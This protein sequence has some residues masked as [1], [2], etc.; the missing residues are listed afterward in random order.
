MVDLY[1]G[2][3]NTHW[4]LHEKLLC[5]WSPFFA[6]IFYDKKTDRAGTTKSYGLPDED[7]HVFEM[8][9]GWLYSRTVP[10]PR[11][12]KEIGPLLELY[13]LAQ[14]L[15][16]EKLSDE[17][18]ETVREFYHSN[19]TYPGLRRVQYIYSETEE[20]N[21]MR[22]MMVGSVARYL[23]L[24]D[25]IPSHWEKALR[26]N[27]QLAVDIIR[28]IQDWHLDNRSVPDARDGSLDRGRG[29]APVEESQIGDDSFQSNDVKEEEQNGAVSEE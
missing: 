21:A 23:T 9:I 13:L 10:S 5:Y 17:I 11:E 4:H 15:E 29:F 24:S 19:N 18:V 26:R 22:E 8:F 6:K 14:K 1:V 3:E 25:K 16:I 27:G 20:D 7:D 2:S 28:S 12:E